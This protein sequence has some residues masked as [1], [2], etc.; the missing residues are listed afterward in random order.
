MSVKNYGNHAL[1]HKK[2]RE[3]SK[4]TLWINKHIQ[5]I[6]VIPAGTRRI[7]ADI[8]VGLWKIA[9]AF[10]VCNSI[11]LA[12]TDSFFRS[13]C[14]V[15]TGVPSPANARES[16]WKRFFETETSRNSFF[17][18]F[19]WWSIRLLVQMKLCISNKVLIGGMTARIYR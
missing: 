6:T 18:N 12:V 13:M 8:T 3:H 14:E 15:T 10:A 2:M 4:V 17:V 1:R 11:F 5:I 16:G 9:V 7:P 19:K